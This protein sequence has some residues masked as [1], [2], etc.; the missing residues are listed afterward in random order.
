MPGKVRP[1]KRPLPLKT[2]QIFNTKGSI[3]NAMLPGTPSSLASMRFPGIVRKK[4]DPKPNTIK[5]YEAARKSL[6]SPV[7]KGR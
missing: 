4:K 3:L 2:R 5:K 6:R 7:K 1:E